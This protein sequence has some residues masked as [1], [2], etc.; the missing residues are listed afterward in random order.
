MYYNLVAAPAF[1]IMIGS[2]ATVFYKQYL[3]YNG[4]LLVQ[5][6]LGLY[7]PAWTPAWTSVATLQRHFIPFMSEETGYRKRVGVRLSKRVATR[8]LKRHHPISVPDFHLG[9][10]LS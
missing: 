5:C 2:S 1:I 10:D 6:Q 3:S 4:L 7:L 9:G 8:F